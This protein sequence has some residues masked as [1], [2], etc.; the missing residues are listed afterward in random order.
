MI[1]QLVEAAGGEAKTDIKTVSVRKGT[2]WKKCA[3]CILENWFQSKGIFGV[4]QSS[5]FPVFAFLS[6]EVLSVLK[7]CIKFF[8]FVHSGAAEVHRQSFAKSA[9]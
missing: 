7:S 8:R 1:S 3:M 5:I 4:M 6:W 9:V 2:C